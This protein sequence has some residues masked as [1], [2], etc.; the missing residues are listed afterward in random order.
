MEYNV[1]TANGTEGLERLVVGRLQQGWKLQGGP[2]AT[3]SHGMRP[4]TQYHQA[5][6]KG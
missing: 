2:F 4:T 1:L 3:T 5:M 6:I